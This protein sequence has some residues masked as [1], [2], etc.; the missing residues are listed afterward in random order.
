V[1]LLDRMGTLVCVPGETR[2]DDDPGS[3]A[4]DLY[5]ELSRHQDAPNLNSGLR[6]FLDL[7]WADMWIGNGGFIGL[8]QTRAA[9]IRRLPKA[10]ER[11]GAPAFAAL[12][13]HANRL[14]PA[15]TLDSDDALRAWLDSD[16]DATLAALVNDLDARYHAGGD[17]AEAL[18]RFVLA[19]PDEF[20]R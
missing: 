20:P 8:W 11:I 7:S 16:H 2:H 4:I 6:A 14:L 17:L 19:N 5:A 10:A 9:T 12:F 18:G 13:Q 3:M 15:G 1:H